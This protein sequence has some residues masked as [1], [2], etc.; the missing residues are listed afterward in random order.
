MPLRLSQS[1]SYPKDYNLLT[2]GH[3]LHQTSSFSTLTPIVKNNLMCIEGRINRP[4]LTNSNNQIIICK[5][6][7]L[8]KLLVKECQQKSFHIDR[9]HNLERVISILPQERLGINE[10]PFE[11]AEIQF[12]GPILVKLSNKTQANPA[13]TKTLWCNFYMHGNTCC[14]FG[15]SRWPHKL[16][17]YSVVT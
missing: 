6:H 9:E 7:P 17:V 5:S 8:S 16:L 3:S 1:G 11:N 15:N 4:D 14:S 12:F 10:K 2:T 13:K